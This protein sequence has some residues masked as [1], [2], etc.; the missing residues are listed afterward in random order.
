MCYDLESI[1]MKGAIE[2]S[3]HKEI[4]FDPRIGAENLIKNS[5]I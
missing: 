4:D 2:N 1:F 5:G 3:I